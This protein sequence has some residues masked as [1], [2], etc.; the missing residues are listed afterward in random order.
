MV[1]VFESKAER[2]MLFHFECMPCVSDR[3]S[4]DSKTMQAFPYF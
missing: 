4:H 2:Y 1:C 3:D